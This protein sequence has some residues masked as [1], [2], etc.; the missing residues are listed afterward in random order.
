M[1]VVSHA[2]HERSGVDQFDFAVYVA[3]APGVSDAAAETAIARVS[4][5]YANAE[6]QSRSEYI[7][8]RAAQLDQLVNLM[9]RLL[10]LAVVIALLGIANRMALSIYERTREIGLLRAV[11]M[12]R[13]QTRRSVGWESVLISALGAGLGVVIGV[14]FGWAIS[15]TIRGAG[16]GVATV[17]AVALAVVVVLAV[18]GG[19]VAAVR[20]AWRAAHVDVLRAI[21]S[22]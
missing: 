8:A 16:L 9:Y 14:F 13:G 20:P 4:D 2:L 12:T 11:G 3:K 15:V 7:D 21:A 10:G 5:A 6:L 19:V 18:L 17:P 1:F 22:E